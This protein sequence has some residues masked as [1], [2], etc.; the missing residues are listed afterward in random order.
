MRAL[1]IAA[2]MNAVEVAVLLVDKGASINAGTHVL[3]YT[4][5]R[6]CFLVFCTY[7]LLYLSDIVWRYGFTH[8]R[9]E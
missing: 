1:H 7:L 4:S 9:R 8:S 2:S 6:T 3:P 5:Y